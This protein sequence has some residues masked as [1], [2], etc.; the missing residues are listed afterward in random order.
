MNF[1]PTDFVW[2]AA[3]S[4]HQIE[5]AVAIDGR[6]PSVWDVFAHTP[7]KV[8]NN[9][10][11][12]EACDHYRRAGE[13]VGLM[14]ELGLGGYRFSISWSRVLPAGIGAVNQAGLDFYDRFVDA[15]CA[16]GIQPFVTL[17][18]WDFPYELYCRGGWLNRDS[19]DW[20]AE[21]TRVVVERLS[22]R[23][24]FWMTHN[25][26]QCTVGLGHQLGIH[27]PGDQLG[28][29]QVLRINH[30][31]LLS[32]GRA[33]QAIRAYAKQKSAIGLAPVGV[34][35]LP[36]STA[37]EDIEA[38][39]QAT[40]SLSL[41]GKPNTWNQVLYSDPIFFKR[42]PDEAYTIF[43]KAMP[44]V[45]ADDLAMI[46][47]P[48]DFFG[49]NIYHAEQIAR[50]GADGKPELLSR[51]VGDARTL[52]YWPVTPEVLYWGPR[53]IYERHQLPIYITENGISLSDWVALDGA[54]HDPQRIDYTTRYLRE[55]RRAMSDGV[56]VRG[57]FHWS[58]MDN[59][60]WAEGYRQRFGLV[61]VDYPTQRR[62]PKDSARWYAEVIR[63]NGANL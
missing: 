36:A 18:H 60:E 7:G 58:L 12:D 13:D 46:G 54:V 49:C 33:V 28:W 32:H 34:T 1:F 50:M 14:R 45:A 21:Y 3:T 29:A 10:N 6:G 44:Q 4:S 22:D 39:R 38:A 35:T 56:D 9:Q 52:A 51:P 27:A 55:L 25:E 43:G 15:L 24:R 26:P 59:F 19:A 11:A 2:G 30:H 41:D 62:I 37:P 8:W 16:A 61:Y 63:L 40:F 53:F 47:Q 17:F 42:Y 20:F 48:L 23:V 57:Y 31:L 5:G